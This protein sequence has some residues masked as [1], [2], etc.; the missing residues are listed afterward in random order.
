MNISTCGYDLEQL[1]YMVS[2]GTLWLSQENVIASNPILLSSYL[3]SK[4]NIREIIK[5][6]EICDEESDN[7]NSS[8][9]TKDTTRD[10]SIS[11]EEKP[12]IC[13]TFSKQ[14]CLESQLEC[15]QGIHEE[16]ETFKREVCS[17]QFSQSA[18]LIFQGTYTGEKYFSC[19]EYSKQFSQIGNLK[20]HQRIHTGEKLTSVISVMCLLLKMVI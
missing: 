15:Y 3:A 19:G 1:E 8:V 2:H 10:I 11:V 16:E 6:E 4:E 17:K 14:F 20:Q 7:G 18:N 12:Y 9:A 5:I 13:A